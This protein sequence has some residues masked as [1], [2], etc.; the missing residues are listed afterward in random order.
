MTSNG[1]S[2]QASAD[3]SPVSAPARSSAPSLSLKGPLSFSFLPRAIL[4]WTIILAVLAVT[5]WGSLTVAHARNPIHPSA[6]LFVSPHPDDEFQMWSLIED[7][8]LEYTVFVFLTRGEES[9]FCDPP[10]YS[11]AL[12]ENLGEVAAQPPPAGKGTQE[13][14]EGRI[15]ATL[16]FLSAMSQTD[17]SIPGDFGEPQQFFL[18]ENTDLEMC[19]VDDGQRVCDETVRQVNIWHDVHDRGAVVFFHLGDGDLTPP[20]IEFALHSLLDSREQWGLAPEL[21]VGAMV[22]AFANDGSHPC[23]AYPHPD[24]LAVHEVLWNVDFHEGPQLGATCFLNR[25]Q[26]MSASVSS[27]AVET[28]FSVAEDGTRYGAHERYYGWLHSQTYPLAHVRQSAL[29]HRIQTFWVRFN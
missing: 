15:N 13:C 25:Y 22:G 29:F 16:G 8:P 9:R 26:R 4:G 18:P 21:P 12:Q 3:E 14:I 23:Y 6:P 7:R 5:V 24:H 10:A 20:T 19:R 11:E 1:L 2:S 27:V 17:P 28:A